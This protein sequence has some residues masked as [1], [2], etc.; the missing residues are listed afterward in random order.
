MVDVVYLK[1]KLKEAINRN[2][3]NL[4]YTYNTKTGEDS[5]KQPIYSSTNVDLKGITQALSL[6]DVR[7]VEA[8]YLPNHYLHLYLY[9]DDVTFNI[10]EMVDEVSIGGIKYIV[11]LKFAYR[12]KGEVVYWKLLL[13]RKIGV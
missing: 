4:T 8:G 13:R 5:Y 6:D 3:V 9:P 2:G 10:T 11:R 1:N 7:F 12:I